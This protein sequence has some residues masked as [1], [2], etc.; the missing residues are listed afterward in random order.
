MLFIN[1]LVLLFF[2]SSY[3]LETKREHI[4]ISKTTM[5]QISKACFVYSTFLE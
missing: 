5:F 4:P 2:V 1:E 3:F